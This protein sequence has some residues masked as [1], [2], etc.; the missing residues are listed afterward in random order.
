MTAATFTAGMMVRTT[1]LLTKNGEVRTHRETGAVQCQTMWR[2]MGEP[3]WAEAREAANRLVDG[4]AKYV[5]KTKY[6]RPAA[7]DTFKVLRILKHAP[8]G[9][10]HTIQNVTEVMGTDGLIWLVETAHLH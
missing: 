9:N 10:W 2:V 5:E 4:T 1:P 3:E 7:D 8:A 6:A